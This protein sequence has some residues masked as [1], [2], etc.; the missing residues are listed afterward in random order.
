MLLPIQVVAQTFKEVAYTPKETKFQLFAPNDAKQITVRIYKEGMGGKAI[1]SVKMQK[2]GNECWTATVKG[3]L[4]GKFYTFDMGKGECAGIFAKAVGVNGK[5]GA[6]IDMEKT[7]PA[8]WCCDQHPVIKSPADLVIY[9]MHHRDFSI[10]RKDAK[11]PGKFL[12]LT[13]P[14]AIEHLKSL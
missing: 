4:M 1:K 3:D 7:N 12:A 13:E 2:T 6:I 5:R 11:Y 8:H 9:E 14:W 10:N